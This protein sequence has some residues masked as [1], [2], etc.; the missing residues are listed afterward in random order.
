LLF[1]VCLGK[2]L[3]AQITTTNASPYNTAVNLVQN[4]LLG[5]GVVASNITASGQNGQYGFFNGTNSNI[6]LDSGVVMSSGNISSIQP[7]GMGTITS[8]QAT[9]PAG[10]VNDLKSVANSAFKMLNQPYT[11]STVWDMTVIEFDFIPNGDSLKFNYVFASNEYLTFV[12]SQYNDVFGFFIYGP[13]ITPTDNV[14]NATG[15]LGADGNPD[16]SVYNIG[17]TN[18]YPQNIAVVPGTNPGLPI[19]I[20][21]I[22]PGSNSQYYID[23]PS[24]TTVYMNGFTTVFQA[25]ALVQCGQTYHIRLAVAD[26][27]DG[28]LDTGVFLEGGSFSSNTNIT[29]TAIPP[30]STGPNTGADTAL[31]EGCGP[32]T[33]NF[34]RSGGNLSQSDTIV[35]NYLGNAI[36]GADYTFLPDTV[37]FLPGQDT[38]TLT[39]DPIADGLPEGIDTLIIAL[40]ADTNICSGLITTGSYLILTISDP[41]PLAINA[42]NDTMSCLDDSVKIGIAIVAGIP[43]FTYTWNTGNTTDS[44]YVNPVGTTNYSITVTDGCNA[45]TEVGFVSVTVLSN[46]IFL[47]GN[48]NSIAC[49]GDSALI[50]IGIT[51]GS[52][53]YQIWWD[54]GPTN[55]TSQTVYPTTTTIYNVSVTDTCGID[56]VTKAITVLVNQYDSL[57]ALAGTSD[58]IH[59]PKD[60]YVIMGGATGGSGSYIYTW[61]N[62]A[63]S[64]VSLI[65][66][67]NTTTTYTLMVTDYCRFDTATATITIFVP[68]YDTLKAQVF[69]ADTLVCPYGKSVLKVTATGGSGNYSYSW[70]SF[71]GNADSTVFYPESNSVFYVTVTDD[72]FNKTV[73]TIPVSVTKP[74]A[75]FMFDF[76]LNGEVLF[77]NQS[78]SDA[79]FF[80]WA[81]GD[82]DTTGT[83]NPTHNY[84]DDG[85]Y[86]VTLAVADS[87]GCVDTIVKEVRPPLEIWIPTAFTPNGDGIN[88]TWDINGI[89]IRKFEVTVFNRWGDMVF[90]SENIDTRWDG[91]N[92]GKKLPTD[93]YVYKLKV[94]GYNRYSRQKNGTV[95]IVR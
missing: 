90:K 32:V 73:K 26:A 67:P 45:D 77:T 69:S 39:F 91:T 34:V 51:G 21:S 64:V 5:Q 74:D 62:W 84:R 72:C 75:E 8:T 13:G 2:Y 58:S 16:F 10:I 88:D 76:G 1:C 65:V 24:K 22:H 38:L 25:L 60:P 81:F 35:L 71:G 87:M 43:P 12:N 57:I 53:G 41:I 61:T 33:L 83:E 95:T 42:V 85:V 82:G 86:L 44:M 52:P 37:V 63:D 19:T 93:V 27:S 48:N 66:N 30:N 59:C 50:G 49:P 92:D 20:S 68:K 6:G 70:S 55:I 4:V 78:S 36:M 94:T 46:T 17:G 3:P 54:N 31:Y 11:V 40:A 79:I 15:N 23:N 9:T 28:S 14:N 7:P 47:T 80:G 18:Y 56:T 89:G 29:L